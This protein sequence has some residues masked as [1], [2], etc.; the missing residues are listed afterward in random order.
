MSKRDDAPGVET[1]LISSSRVQRSSSGGV[2][3][4]KAI[5]GSV[6][7][8]ILFGRW[9]IDPDV[10]LPAHIHS[11]DTIAYCVTGSC[12]FRVGEDLEEGFE[13]GP[14]DYAYIPAGV[15]HTEATGSEGVELVFARDRQGGETTMVAED[16]G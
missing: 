1:M 2:V 8:E 9:V 7:R 15:M 11:A 10:D 3:T 14:G 12:S 6:A 16:G 13:I 4:E 5:D